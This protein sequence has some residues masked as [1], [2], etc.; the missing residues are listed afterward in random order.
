VFYCFLYDY[1][2]VKM[3]YLNVVCVFFILTGCH[4]CVINV[5][6]YACLILGLLNLVVLHVW[7]ILKFII[8]RIRHFFAVTRLDFKVGYVTL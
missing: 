5:V 3:V 6:I 7:G 4:L 8:R 1:F 2:D